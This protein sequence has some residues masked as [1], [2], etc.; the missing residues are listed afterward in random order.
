MTTTDTALW[1]PMSP[2][3][4]AYSG[5]CPG[6]NKSDLYWIGTARNMSPS[7]EI[8]AGARRLGKGAVVKSCG[9]AAW[10]VALGTP[11]SARRAAAKAAL[12]AQVRTA[13]E[14]AKVWESRGHYVLT[15]A[16]GHCSPTMAHRRRVL[17][18]ERSVGGDY[19]ARLRA[20]VMRERQTA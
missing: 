19:I 20:A 12:A 7:R 18:V 16:G 4:K 11:K 5:A 6:D 9:D 8:P 13:P 3:D 1:A 14:W 2:N 15:V 17:A 10:V